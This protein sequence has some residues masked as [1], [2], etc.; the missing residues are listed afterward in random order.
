[1]SNKKYLYSSLAAVFCILIAT[2]GWAILT[3]G[4]TI[5]TDI[6]TANLT[7]TGNASTTGTFDVTGNFL[8]NT[9]KFVVTAASGN[10]AIAGTLTITSNATTSG[11]L[12]VQGSTTLATSTIGANFYIDASG[13]A[14]TTGNMI[15]GG[16]MTADA[17]RVTSGS[18]IAAT[19]TL[20]K[21]EMQAA[22]YWPV[23]MTEGDIQVTLCS[24]SALDTADIGRKLTFGVVTA[25]GTLTMADGG[26]CNVAT[27]GAVLSFNL[28]KFIVKILF[29]DTCNAVA[30]GALD[31]VGDFMECTV[32]AANR[33]TCVPQS[34]AAVE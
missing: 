23:D 16:S 32:V 9:N 4:T 17:F 19:G 10:T 15:I 2:L 20:S 12:V 6:T 22:S 33:I 14:S 28:R 3:Y 1:M 25:G 7:A 5:G 24:D 29:G 11:N 21:A 8:V 13:N 31:G 18:T 30:V 27:I 34:I 26:N